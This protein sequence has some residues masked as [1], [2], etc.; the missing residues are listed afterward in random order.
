MA[1]GIPAGAPDG[2]SALVSLP[3]V[4]SKPYGLFLVSD[5]VT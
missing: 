1:N 5:Q 4:R 2:L 3:I